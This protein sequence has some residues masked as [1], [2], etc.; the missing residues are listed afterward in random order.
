MKKHIALVIIIM[1]IAGG[2]IYFKE[3]R[4]IGVNSAPSSH[5][6]PKRG[7]VL[8]KGEFRSL[9]VQLVPG[10]IGLYRPFAVRSGGDAVCYGVLGYFEDG[11]TVVVEG[12]IKYGGDL[13]NVGGYQVLSPVADPWWIVKIT[14]V[15]EAS[16]W[17]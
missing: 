1:L 11:T 7:E 3:L 5:S 10:Y 17:E 2:L 9:D 12:N 16:W 15:H 13:G 6:P 4:Y 14:D 8:I